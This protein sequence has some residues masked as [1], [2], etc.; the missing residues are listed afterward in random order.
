MKAFPDAH[1]TIRLFL[2]HSA[3]YAS[4]LAVEE[5][6]KG[7][8]GILSLGAKRQLTLSDKPVSSV[9]HAIFDEFVFITARPFRLHGETLIQL[10]YATAAVLRTLGKSLTLLI[11]ILGTTS[12]QTYYS[13][14]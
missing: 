1:P 11:V 6:A 8:R 2:T 14:E 9:F 10:D 12:T 5:S 4:S 3:G 13:N 7:L